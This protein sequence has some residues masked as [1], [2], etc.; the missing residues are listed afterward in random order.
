MTKTYLV[1]KIAIGIKE[2]I[3]KPTFVATGLS[4]MSNSSFLPAKFVSNKGLSLFCESALF[5][6]DKNRV[7][8][9]AP[10]LESEDDVK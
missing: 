3:L 10:L 5:V 1:K 2:D 9:K 7:R 4:R 6:E 8:I